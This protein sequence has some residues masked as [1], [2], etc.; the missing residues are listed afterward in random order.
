MIPRLPCPPQPLFQGH[1]RIIQPALAEKVHPAVRSRRPEQSWHGVDNQSNLVF[2]LLGHRDVHHSSDK[3]QSAQFI[4]ASMSHDMDVFHGTIWHQQPMFK[5]EV[6]PVL[7]RALNGLFHQGGVFRMDTLEHTF[8]CRGG[9]F[10]VLEDS[11]GFL[12][13]DDLARGNFPAKTS[14]VTE[15]LRFRQVS[16]AS[17]QLLLLQFQGLGG[18]SP[19]HRGRQQSQPEDDQGSRDNSSGAERG[20]AYGPGQVRGH[21]GGRKMG[22]GHASVMHDG[23][24]RAH[25]DGA[26]YLLPADRHFFITE[27]KGDP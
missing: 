10:I 8:H 17:L 26:S 20:D 2:R 24:R 12:R 6:L 16:L 14:G 4:P 7:R 25:H 3:L 5:I 19:I 9:R 18:E 13:P 21:A 15:P 23:D 27:V 1:S 11:I 22:G